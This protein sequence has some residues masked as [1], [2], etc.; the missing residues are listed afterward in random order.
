MM[1]ILSRATPLL[2]VRECAHL[3][4]KLLQSCCKIKSNRT[5]LLEQGGA[6]ALLGMLPEALESAKLAGVAERILLTAE[7]LLEHWARAELPA[8]GGP[9]PAGEGAPPAADAS[10]AM[11]GVE[12]EGGGASAMEVDVVGDVAAAWPLFLSQLLASLNR[13]CVRD[14]KPLVQAVTRLLP[15]VTRGQPALI[16]ALLSHFVPATDFDG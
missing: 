10:V 3:L 16:T 5:R 6:Q 13:A 2:R 11:E 4:L 15:L 14:S 1:D 8:A 9:P 7:S 12:V